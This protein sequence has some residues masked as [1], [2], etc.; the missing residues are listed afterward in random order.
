MSMAK[1][2]AVGSLHT[3]TTV[4]GS[5]E[6]MPQLPTPVSY[7]AAPR[8]AKKDCCKSQETQPTAI[9]NVSL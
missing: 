3:V 6:L 1:P 4:H 7:K 5:L 8:G 2:F 9:L